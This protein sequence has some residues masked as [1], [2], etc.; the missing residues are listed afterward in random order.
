MRLSNR[1]HSAGTSRF[2]L[3]MVSMIDVVFLLLIFFLVTTSFIRPE[4]RLASTIRVKQIDSAAAINSDLEPATI[5][6][7]PVGDRIVFRIGQVESEKLSAI[8]DVLKSFRNK[9]GGA[10]VR[11]ADS[12]PFDMPARAIDLCHK[13]GF[14]PV[15]Y[16]P[17]K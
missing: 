2:E 8:E 14:R 9:D 7:I 16:I 17:L 6:I 13:L 5:D 15:T 10:F 3:S 1:R 4:L 12:A 11:A